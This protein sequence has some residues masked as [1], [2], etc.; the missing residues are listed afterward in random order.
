VTPGFVVRVSVTDEQG[1]DNVQLLVDDN[2]VGSIITPPYAFNAPMSLSN[3]PHTV[4]VRATD[5]LQV[6]GTK[7]ITVM[8]GEPCGSD[9]ACQA[10]NPDLVC[11]DGRC[12][13]GE[14][15]SGGLGTD[16]TAATDCFSGLCATKGDKNLCTESCDLAA[17]A[18]PD[19]YECLSNGAG[20]GLCWPSEGGCLGCSTDGG[21]PRPTLPIAGGAILA[22]VL[23]RRRRRRA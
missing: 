17:N 18:C 14:S 22:A 12:V 7:S 8:V 10:A 9:A 20:G 2:P 3:G 19:S 5:I 11:V 16:C 15:T 4:T 23:V 6:V 1:V 13:P 21:T